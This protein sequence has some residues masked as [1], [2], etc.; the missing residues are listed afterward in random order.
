MTELI[1]EENYSLDKNQVRID[2]TTLT[3]RFSVM[4]TNSLNE[5]VAH[6]NEHGYAIFS[7]IMLQDEINTNKD[8]LWKFLENIPGRQIRRNDPM[9][10]SDNWPGNPRFGLIAE[11][12][13]G[14]SDFMWNVRSNRNTKRVYSQIWNTNE[15]LVSLDGCGIYRNWRYEPQWKTVTGWYHVDQN[16]VSKPD[17]CAIQGF[18]SLTDQNETTGGL[19]LFPGTHLRFNEL[20]DV[21]RREKD[22]IPIPSDH[23]VLNRGRAIGK[24]IHCRAGDLVVWDSRVIH[25][26]SPAFVDREQLSDQPNELI[27]IVAYVSMGPTTFVRDYTLGQF[28]KQRK[29]MVQNNCTLTH[30]T[31]ELTKES[32]GFTLPR[33]SLEKL[34]AYQRSLIIG[35]NIDDE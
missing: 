10:W 33:V 31:F 17:R 9:T 16:P 8:L 12:G 3:S 5:G 6:L 24:F 27:R 28:Q 23:P 21:V 30:W 22:F 20:V 4:H 25:C 15:L 26:N 2:Y 14:Q 35:T 29:L 32:T 18:V 19:I 7:D 1:S 11:C 13:V 34:D